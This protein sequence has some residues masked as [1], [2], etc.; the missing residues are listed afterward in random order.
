MT[1]GTNNSANASKNASEEDGGPLH[2][3]M[4]AMSKQL[5]DMN[6]KLEKIES[7]ETE[8]RGLRVLINDLKNKNKELKA[9]ARAT[10]R[11][12]LEMNE[13]NNA[14]ENRLNNLE[15]HHRGW[16]A[17]VLNIQLSKEEEGDNFKVRDKVY[18]MALLP[19]L[20]GAVEKNLL[21][22]VP[23]AD[24][25]L[26]VA[27]VLPGPAGQP[28]PIIM[29][30]YNRNVRDLCFRLKKH[31]AP[32]AGRGG[33]GEGGAGGGGARGGR[34]GATGDA[35][36]EVGAEEAGGFEGRGR[37]LY[38]FYEDLTWASFQKMRAIAKDS[39]VKACW[40]VKG[41]IKF[42]LNSKPEEVRRVDSLLDSLDIILK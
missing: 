14:L 23:T 1:R 13:K 39:R 18:N 6:K 36:G 32:R 35:G 15:Q 4:K 40:S 5:T 38:P 30:F 22:A 10:D 9:E 33:A 31:F 37:Y 25:L 16:S 27:H 41:Q 42:I 20:R 21:P 26:E 2:E 7:I 3:M 8:V 12:L 34:G 17:R 29:R 24:Q 19:I 11:K 28:K